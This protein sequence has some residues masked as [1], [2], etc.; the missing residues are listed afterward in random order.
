MKYG[1]LMYKAGWISMMKQ[2]CALTSLVAYKVILGNGL[3][4]YL[5]VG[6]SL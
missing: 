1:T 5:E 3:A 2:V 6:T 4:P